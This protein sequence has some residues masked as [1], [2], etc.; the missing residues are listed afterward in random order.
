[1]PPGAAHIDT[2]ILDIAFK[3]HASTGC[4]SLAF[5]QSLLMIFCVKINGHGPCRTISLISQLPIP[6]TLTIVDIA[7]RALALN[8]LTTHYAPL[9]S[10]V[11]TPDFTQQRWSQPDN[12]RLPQ[13]FFARLTPAWQRHCALRTDYARRMALV[14]I[15]VLVAQALGLTLDELLLVY[16]VQFPVMQQYERD[17]WYD[18]HG[19][20]IFTNSKG[21]VGVG[22]PRKGGT[23]QPKA[24][25]TLPDGT[26]REGQFGWED[27][28]DL[29][30]GAV[31]QQWVQ[32]DTL[33]TGPYLK[34]RR[35]VA[36]FA[37]AS[38][39]EDYRI[40]WAFFAAQTAR[41]TTVDPT[42]RG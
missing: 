37:R 9:W 7:I 6:Q 8:C 17:T 2:W 36:P 30:D 33:P 1:M 12:P 40:A 20:I 4:V 38:R 41:Q 31:V 24:R 19:R 27:V 28:Q 5:G 13:D 35:W 11:F 42:L 16:R 3:Q 29:P 21:L 15:D 18:L 26:V 32:D 10:E 34:E 39:E 22:L 23:A 14:E 25:L